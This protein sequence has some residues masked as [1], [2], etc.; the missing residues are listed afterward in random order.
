M[1][2][3][4]QYRELVRLSRRFGTLLSCGVPILQSME[5]VA[6]ETNS[7]YRE[8]FLE[9]RQAIREGNN[10]SKSI[11]RWP[12]LFPAPFSGLIY[13]GEATGTLDLT[14][15]KAA[16]LLSPALESGR[17]NTAEAWQSLQEAIGAIQFTHQYNAL[18]G[19][20]VMWWGRCLF[21][22]EHEAPPPFNDIAKDLQQ[23]S[24]QEQR[25][26]YLAERMERFPLIFS[27][28]YRAMV[29]TGDP[30]RGNLVEAMR[31]LEEL[32]LEDWQLSQRVGWHDGRPSLIIDR[33]MPA[34][35]EWSALTP[36]EQ[37]ITLTLFCRT[38][39]LLLSTGI[40]FTEALTT[41]SQL[42]PA[43]EQQTVIAA[44]QLPELKE[45]NTAL[46]AA[47]FLPGFII[48]LL[49]AGHI[50]G[51]PEFTMNR[52]ADALHAEVSEQ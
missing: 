51:T 10:L 18:L 28:F 26:V 19:T 38:I 52:A 9:M 25:W 7:P 48:A 34:A 16:E 32:L 43:A 40:A 36:P 41:A 24:Q 46:Y 42:L 11:E 5:L 21:I 22:L 1:T 6:E 3:N 29:Q 12:D 27:S 31:H 23:Q 33:G 13:E 39:S 49:R 14:M 47:G 30:G 35:P 45:I 8:A 2:T 37:L 20:G 44:A 17:L 50:G 15:Q 4:A